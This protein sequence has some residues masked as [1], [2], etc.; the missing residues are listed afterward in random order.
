[1]RESGRKFGL[2]KEKKLKRSV[3]YQISRSVYYAAGWTFS[4]KLITAGAK[5]TLEGSDHRLHRIAPQDHR[6]QPGLTVELVLPN[7]PIAS[8]E[9]SITS[10]RL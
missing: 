10:T 3:H 7:R 5:A 4:S 2:C 6:N 9:T 8:T 1:M